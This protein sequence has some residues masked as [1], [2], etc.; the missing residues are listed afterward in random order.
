MKLKE[1]ERFQ[2]S[3]GNIIIKAKNITKKIKVIRLIYLYIRFLYNI[4]FLCLL[5]TANIMKYDIKRGYNLIINN[6]L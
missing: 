3:N 4:K 6:Y 5:L 2:G 1:S